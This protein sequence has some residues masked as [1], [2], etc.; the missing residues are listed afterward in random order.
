MRL[1]LI[2]LLKYLPNWD[3]FLL[4]IWCIPGS[5]I[6]YTKL[7]SDIVQTIFYYI[8]NTLK[9]FIN[10]ATKY[11]VVIPTY[12][13]M[14]GSKTFH[15]GSICLWNDIDLSIKN[16][17]SHKHFLSKLHNNFFKKCFLRT[18]SNF[19]NILGWK[20]NINSILTQL[21]LTYIHAPFC[22]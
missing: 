12:K 20:C 5:L 6:C 16:I 2:F 17:I 18:F 3:S 19:T 15:V 8:S 9:K 4:I 14:S 13:W 21:W 1:F 22:I 7:A 10:I 11:T